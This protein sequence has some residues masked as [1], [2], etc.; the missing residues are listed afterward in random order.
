MQSSYLESEKNLWAFTLE[1]LRSLFS[2]ETIR[3]SKAVRQDIS[4]HAVVLSY[5]YSIS[6]WGCSYDNKTRCEMI[7]KT[8]TV[9]A[10]SFEGVKNG[11]PVLCAANTK[12]INRV[13]VLSGTLLHLPSPQPSP[14]FGRGSKR[15]RL[16]LRL[17]FSQ[18]WEKGLGDEGNI[19]I[20]LS[21]F[22][23]LPN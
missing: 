12:Q 9:S 20:I 8:T 14:K 1:C 11:C 21:R 10:K 19:S 22:M 23:L 13:P 17:P 18:A 4:V 15:L 2:N 7:K 16:L 5:C 3:V 6:S